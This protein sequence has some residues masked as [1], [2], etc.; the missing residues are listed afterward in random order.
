MSSRGSGPCDAV[1]P[2]QWDALWLP[3]AKEV[4][5]ASNV[6]GTGHPL[7]EGQR[8]RQEHMS[9]ERGSGIFQIKLYLEMV[10][11]KGLF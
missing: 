9:K 11:H 6:W 1:F 3:Q 7:Q 5:V 2:P 8:P 10:E 4:E